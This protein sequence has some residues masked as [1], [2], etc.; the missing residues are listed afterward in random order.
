[1][2]MIISVHLALIS[3]DCQGQC[4]HGFET[5]PVSVCRL[6][7]QVK[8]RAARGRECLMIDL[9][10]PIYQAASK[11]VARHLPNRGAGRG[12]L[13]AGFLLRSIRGITAG[14]RD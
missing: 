2:Q 14:K 8:I 12:C 13:S 11:A 10:Q 7:E 6:N 9:D 1:M 3:A 4:S 5:V